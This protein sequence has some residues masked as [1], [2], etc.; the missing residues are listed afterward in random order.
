MKYTINEQANE[1]TYDFVVPYDEYSVQVGK[2]LDMLCKKKNEEQMSLN[3]F[4][5]KYGKEELNHV[6]LNYPIGEA[7]RSVVEEKKLMVISQPR[8]KMGNVDIVGD[9]TFSITIDKKLTL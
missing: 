8:I 9:V 2:A 7:Y 1:I 3:D 5:V 6:A 4:I